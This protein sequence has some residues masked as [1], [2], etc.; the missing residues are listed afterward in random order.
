[1]TTGTQH[2]VYTKLLEV[3]K[4]L[5]EERRVKKSEKAAFARQLNPPDDLKLDF[6]EKFHFELADI[7]D[8]IAAIQKRINRMQPLL[9][10]MGYFGW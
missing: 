4:V 2:L 9:K 1:M 5:Q 7:E 3:M 6:E 10:K 8:D